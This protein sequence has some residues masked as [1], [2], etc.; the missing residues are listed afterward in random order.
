MI[1]D[2]TAKYLSAFFDATLKYKVLPVRFV[3]GSEE[4]IPRFELVKTGKWVNGAVYYLSTICI[5]QIEAF[6]IWQVKFSDCSIPYKLYAVGLISISLFVLSA[7][8]FLHFKIKDCV[9][10]SNI[11]LRLVALQGKL[12]T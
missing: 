10:V 7:N 3:N 8:S 5:L 9:A 11:L 2:K 6:L 1:S 12:D 4:R